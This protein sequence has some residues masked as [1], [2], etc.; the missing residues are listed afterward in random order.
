MDHY[1]D[2]RL[3]P[4]PEFSAP[5][6]MGALFGKAHRALVRVGGGKIGVSFP[7]HVLSPRTLGDCLRF[8]GMKPELES[9]MKLQWLTGIADHVQVSEVMRIPDGSAHRVVSRVQLKT[10]VER[11]RRRYVQR[12]QVTDE[13]ARRLI[14]DSVEQKIPLPYLSIRS[15]STGQTFALF[16]EHRAL[17]VEP[18]EGVFNSYGMS[19][20]ATVPWF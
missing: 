1:I 8:H 13:E 16:V 19:T 7:K 3:R 20:T 6:L 11:L 15:Q 2:I 9:L 10:N 12:H 14:P 17:Q 4:D 5:L 18:V